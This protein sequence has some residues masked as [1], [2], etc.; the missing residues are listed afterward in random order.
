[1][2]LPVQQQLLAPAGTALRQVTR[3][4]SHPQPLGQCARFLRDRLPGAR[5]EATHSTADAAIQELHREKP[6]FNMEGGTWTNNISW[7]RGYENVL[8]PMNRLSADF[9]RVLDNRRV[10]TAGRPYRNALYHLLVSQ[11]SCFRYWGQGL[12][13]DYAREI[14]RRGAEILE[15]DFR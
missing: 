11:T 13:T 14:C 8:T 4:L 10:D 12:W 2:L 7:V 3:V 9:H 5:L 1:V 6:G 15:R